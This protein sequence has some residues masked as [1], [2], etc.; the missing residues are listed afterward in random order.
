M[1]FFASVMVAREREKRGCT[2]FKDVRITSTVQSQI[3]CLGAED[4]RSFVSRGTTK[5]R[6][7]KKSSSEA[8][9]VTLFLSVQCR[10]P[11]LSLANQ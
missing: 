10:C 8:R 7:K 11:G 9:Q 4:P 3:K 5:E 2:A 6:E 1:C